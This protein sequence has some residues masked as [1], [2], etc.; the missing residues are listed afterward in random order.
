MYESQGEKG[1]TSMPD[2]RQAA[3]GR[4]ARYRVTLS[5]VCGAA[6]LGALSNRAVRGDVR[7]VFRLFR[8]N[9]KKRRDAICSTS[10]RGAPSD[11][12]GRML[13][14]WNVCDCRTP[15]G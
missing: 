9:R 5:Y 14:G 7:H 4:L 3:R 8:S 1:E 2:L 13:K 10:G 15:H 11:D 12:H 6:F